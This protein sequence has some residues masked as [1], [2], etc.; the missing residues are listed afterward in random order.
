MA[1]KPMITRTILSTKVT[2][3]SINLETAEPYNETFILPRTYKDDK[4]ILK[5]LSKSHDDDQHKIVAVV[6]TEVMQKKYGMTE[7]EFID[8]AKEL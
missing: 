1:R 7:Q 4:T 6:A 3:L 2:T 5:I 8:V